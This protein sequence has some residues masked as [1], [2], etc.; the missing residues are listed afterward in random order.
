[1]FTFLRLTVFRKSLTHVSIFLKA[2]NCP[3]PAPAPEEITGQDSWKTQ[4]EG[5]AK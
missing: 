3:A 4:N 2:Q 1:V 5:L